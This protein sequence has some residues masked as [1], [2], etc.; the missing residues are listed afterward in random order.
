KINRSGSGLVALQLQIIE[1]NTSGAAEERNRHS[2]LPLVG[3]N[4]LDRAVE[5]GERAL[6][7]RDGLTDEE[8]DLL[9]HLFRLRIVGDA[10]EAIHLFGAERLR[11]SLVPYE[12]DDPLNPVDRVRRRSEE[13]RVGKGCR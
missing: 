1:L 6:G 7:D 4:F 9:F 11:K 12:L 8:W 3:Q 2:D 13:R 10:E 5:V